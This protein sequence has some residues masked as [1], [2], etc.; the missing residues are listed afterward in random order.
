MSKGVYGA[1]DAVSNL[2][3]YSTQTPQRGSGVTY[4]QRSPPSY[5][6]QRELWAEQQRQMKERQQRILG[7]KS[8]SAASMAKQHLEEVSQQNRFTI[9]PTRVGAK[10]L[11]RI[12]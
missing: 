2:F 10:I 1:Y 5:N 7:H 9:S 6:T 12:L 8:T 3:S 11:S 4:E